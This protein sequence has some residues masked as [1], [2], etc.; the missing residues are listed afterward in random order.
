MGNTYRA[1]SPATVAAYAEGT[2]EHEFTP[3]EEADALGSGLLELVP[4]TY[5]QLSNNFTAAKQ[6]ETFEAAF[7]VEQEA[8]LIQGGHI[9]RVDEKSATTRKKK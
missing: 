7:V 5:L 3:S 6:G 4:R 8:A 9:E 2:F 1:T